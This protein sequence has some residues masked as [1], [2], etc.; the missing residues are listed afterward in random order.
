[1][2]E[3]YFPIKFKREILELFFL[4]LCFVF[5]FWDVGCMGSEFVLHLTDYFFMLELRVIHNC[6]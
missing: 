2:E 1:M 3:I 6:N 5:C 4:F